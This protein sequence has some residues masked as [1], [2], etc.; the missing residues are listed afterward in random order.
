MTLAQSKA[1]AIALGK[2]F[3]S[4]AADAALT[5]DPA[6]VEALCEMY[7][8]LPRTSTKR[9]FSSLGIIVGDSMHGSSTIFA[10][11]KADGPLSSRS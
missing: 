1:L 2:H 8:D 6:L 11:I 10:G 5:K 4:R 3:P 9:R 7:D